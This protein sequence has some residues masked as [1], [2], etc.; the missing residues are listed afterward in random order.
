MVFG[1]PTTISTKEPHIISEATDVEGYSFV[2]IA[3][4]TDCPSMLDEEFIVKKNKDITCTIYNDDNFVEGTGGEPP[5]G[6]GVIFHFDTVSFQLFTVGADNP[7]IC[8]ENG[9][10]LPCVEFQPG[11][12]LIFVVPKLTG[13]QK[14]TPT[15]I[16]LLTIIDTNDN[17][18]TSEC[19]VL[20]I[21]IESITTKRGFIID[22]ANNALELNPHNANFALI[23]S[24]N[25]TIDADTL[26]CTKI[27]EP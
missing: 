3:G 11:T 10:T 22:C 8:S 6:P 15:T 21:G 25:G 5:S 20:G 14:L 2:L 18:R 7:G 17:T 13:T 24:C 1:E 27:V 12:D 9:S 19:S 4:D 16:I 26:E 23:E